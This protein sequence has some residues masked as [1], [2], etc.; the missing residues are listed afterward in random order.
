[1]P[2]RHKTRKP[3]RLL[4]HHHTSGR[5]LRDGDYAADIKPDTGGRIIRKLG[6]DLDRAL[7]LFEALAAEVSSGGDNPTLVEFLVGTFLPTHR[8]LKAD[9]FGESTIR[10]RESFGWLSEHIRVCE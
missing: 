2:R 9:D 7:R 6:N 1:M 10:S 8:R 4:P 5:F 3:I